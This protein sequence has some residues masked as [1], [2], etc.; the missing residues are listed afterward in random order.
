MLIVTVNNFIID[1]NLGMNVH[2]NISKLV[3]WNKRIKLSVLGFIWGI[4][5]AA[6]DPQILLPLIC[7]AAVPITRSYSGTTL[8]DQRKC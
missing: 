3:Q 2:C 6:G 7:S 4:V 1:T 8:P 5:K